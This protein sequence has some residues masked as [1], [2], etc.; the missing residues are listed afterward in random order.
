MEPPTLKNEAEKPAVEPDKQPEAAAPEG[1]AS[2]VADEP[3]KA[4]VDLPPV[5]QK[6]APVSAPAPA[7][8]D[9]IVIDSEGNLQ[10]K[11]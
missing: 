11:E 2:T 7:E 10:I 9:T 4:T 6:P 5:E 1:L 3:E 8:E